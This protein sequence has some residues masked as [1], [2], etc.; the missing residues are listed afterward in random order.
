MR[1]TRLLCDQIF[2]AQSRNLCT[3]EADR[4]QC[5]EEADTL[6]RAM[7]SAHE[8]N[9]LTSP[10]REKACNNPCVDA[11][12]S[13][14]YRP[15]RWPE[16]L[17]LN[18]RSWR[19]TRS[20]SLFHSVPIPH[21]PHGLRYIPS[22]VLDISCL[23]L[24]GVSAEKEREWRSNGELAQWVCWGDVRCHSDFYVVSFSTIVEIHLHLSFPTFKPTRTVI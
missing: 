17:T 6:L 1:N 18:F 23:C 14:V 11:F 8:G 22:I 3:Q 13:A 16:L 9:Y 2:L 10:Q 15:R 12:F 4:E 5:E 19:R 7:Q 20:D 24:F 21:P